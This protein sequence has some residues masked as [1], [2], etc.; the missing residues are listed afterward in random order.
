ML[1]ELRRND[2]APRSLRRWDRDITKAH[3]QF[4]G[5]YGRKPSNAAS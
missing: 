4:V 3:E 1:D 2:W 5:L